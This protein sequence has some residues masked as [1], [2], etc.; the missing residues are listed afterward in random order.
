M[1]VYSIRIHM[2]EQEARKYIL[3]LFKIVSTTS[4][5]VVNQY[6]RIKRI[7]CPFRVIALED[8][9]PYIITGDFYY[10]E[11]VKMALDLKEVFIIQGK[12]YYIRY[13]Q[14]I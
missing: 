12:G 9:P 14:I 13:F 6:G 1:V 3:E 5:L 2:T 11:A 4:I 10:V 8:I 7:N